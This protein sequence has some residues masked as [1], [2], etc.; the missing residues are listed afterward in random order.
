MSALRWLVTAEVSVATFCMCM[1]IS[2]SLFPRHPKSDW[3]RPQAVIR[4]HSDND[5]RRSLLHRVEAACAGIFGH[6]AT[7]LLQR[8]SLTPPFAWP[9]A[10]LQ[11]AAAAALCAGT[12]EQSASLPA[13]SQCHGVSARVRRLGA[14]AEPTQKMCQA[15]ARTSP[16]RQSVGTTAVTPRCRSSNLNPRHVPPQARRRRGRRRAP[17]C[18]ALAG[19]RP[20][21]PPLA[22]ASAALQPSLPAHPLPACRRVG[23]GRGEKVLSRSQAMCSSSSLHVRFDCRKLGVRPGRGRMPEAR[24]LCCSSSPATLNTSNTT[25]QQPDSSCLFKQQN[26]G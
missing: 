21:R 2:E 20:R 1:D 7:E 5:C 8:F 26:E 12:L 15:A 16:Q 25:R 17:A 19:R 4:S 14:G 18:R 6:V 9:A 13:R 10:A 23:V 22:A 3:Q 11:A 24:Q